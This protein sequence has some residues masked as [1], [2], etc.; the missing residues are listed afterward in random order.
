MSAPTASAGILDRLSHSP[1]SQPT[2]SCLPDRP[3]LARTDE[4]TPEL[5]TFGQ[6]NFAHARLG[7]RR[8]THSLIDLTDRFIRHPGGTLPDKCSDPNALRRC[9]DLMNC[10]KVTHAALLKA[11]TEHS[12]ERMRQQTGPV[13][14]IHDT[15]ELDYTGITT[16]QDKLGPLDRSGFHKGYLCHNSL[17]VNPRDRSVF[18]LTNQILHVREPVPEGETIAQKRERETRES[19][20]WVW[21]VEAQVAA[22]ID[23]LWVDVCD[24]GGDTFEFLDREDFLSRKFV[25]RACQDRIIWVGHEGKGRRCLLKKYLQRLPAQAHRT[26]PLSDRPERPARSATVAIAWA[27]VRVLPPRQKRGKFRN[28]PLVVWALRVWEENPPPAAEAV[29]WYLLTNVPVTGLADAW[30]R[31]DWYTCRWVVEEYHKAQKT[32]CG[33]E[34]PQFT[35]VAAL[36]PMIALLSVVALTL[37]QLRDWSRRPELQEEAATAVVAEE[38]VQVLS[39]WRYRCARPLTVREFMLALARLGGHQN[40][41]QDH[42][43]GW[44]VLWRGWTKLQLLVEGARAAKHASKPHHPAKQN[45]KAEH[46]THQ[47]DT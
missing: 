29:D 27:A 37:L 26:I 4:S 7:D 6:Q 39:G 18:G 44:L 3:V 19:L 15:T 34:L 40:R 38:Y 12:Y 13:L 42:V 16:I 45:R 14:I 22:P 28:Q 20:L 32:G 11:H 24:R 35:T 17:A 23:Q 46:K 41:R 9:Y 10:P 1:S 36:Q 31:V 33:I 47:F 30:E 43:P 5:Q 8:R 2:L 25:V 21:A